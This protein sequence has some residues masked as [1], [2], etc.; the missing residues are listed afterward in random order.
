MTL[1]VES[2]NSSQVMR[3]ISPLT[4]RTT[5]II[6]TWNVWTMW[7]TDTTSHIAE[8][9]RRYNLVIIITNETHFTQTGTKI[10][11]L[12]EMLLY[13][14]YK[15]EDKTQTPGFVLTVFEESRNASTGCESYGFRNIK[16]PSKQR[17]IAL[18]RM[19]FGAMHSLEIAVD[20]MISLREAA[21]DHSEVFRKVLYHP[22]GRPK[23]QNGNG[24][25][26][27]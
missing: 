18:Q 15:E 20:M 26:R 25:H 21:T 4:T 5:T 17:K 1:H 24:Q 19:L 13:C 16:Y 8:E 2:R 7:D 3:T 22:D 11:D 27:I 23:R 10:L 9:T 6:G 12:D 14:V